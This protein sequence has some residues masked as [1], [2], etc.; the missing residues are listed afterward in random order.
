VPVRALADPAV[1]RRVLY[2]LTLTLDGRPA[3]GDTWRRRQRGVN[4]AVEY[5]V[6]TGALERSPLKHIRHAGPALSPSSTGLFAAFGLSPELP[7]AGP[8]LVPGQ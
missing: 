7:A 8:P 2:Q 4:T 1:A 6:Q 5:A 3:A